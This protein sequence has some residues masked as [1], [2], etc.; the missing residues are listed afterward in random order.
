MNGR[1]RAKGKP[2][3]I[4]PVQKMTPEDVAIHTA[5]AYL[6]SASRCGPELQK[7]ARQNAL[8]ILQHAAWSQARRPA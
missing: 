1:H 5:N 4:E 7:V 2:V 3:Q 6:M 8:G